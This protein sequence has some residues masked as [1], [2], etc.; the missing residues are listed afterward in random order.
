MIITGNE[1]VARGA[2]AAG[3]HLYAGYPI[4]PATKIMEILSKELPKKGGIFLQTEDEISSIGHVIGA[5]F[6]G[7]RAMTGT[8]GPGFCLMSEFT[9]L[10][11]MAEVPAVI[12]DS[13]RGGPS[14]GMPTKHEQSDLNIALFGGSGDSPRVVIAPR[15]VGECYQ[16]TILALYIAEKYQTLVIL[17]L[18][19]FLSNSIRNMDPPQPPDPKYLNANIS[20][21]P[22]DL[23]DYK[24]YK[25]TES[26]ISP[27]SIPGTP[28]GMFFSTGLEHDERGKPVYDTKSHTQMTEKRYRKHDGV[29]KEMPAALIS[30]ADGEVDIGVISWGSSAGAAAEAVDLAC[31]EGLRAACFSSMFLS[32]FPDDALRSFIGRC[33]TLLVPEMNYSGQFANLIARYVERPMV[34]LNMVTGLPMAS[35]DILKK[36]KEMK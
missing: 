16:A 13:Q 30:G 3:L 5:G 36:M 1:A 6:A 27:R 26:G 11:V 23:G 33:R 7:R 19:F 28:G 21:T 32:P 18:D 34:R 12:V 8:S 15:N 22:D 25:M 29:A 24:R 31:R 2:L 17:L 14:T 20:P 35:E 4:T 9:G 10:S